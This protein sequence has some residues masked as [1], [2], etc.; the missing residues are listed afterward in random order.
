[1]TREQDQ[2]LEVVDRDTA[3]TRWWDWLRPEVL[4]VEDVPLALALGRVLGRDVV[5]E[6]DVPPFD[7]SNVDGFAV[8]AQDTF[9]A[10]KRRRD[11]SRSTRRKSPR[12]S[13]RV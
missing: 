8:Q 4:D 10:A 12:V 5:A 3:E 6:V 7:R 2:F 9:G 1:M 13:C 11:P